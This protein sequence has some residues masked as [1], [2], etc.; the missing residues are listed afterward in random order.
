MALTGCGGGSD[1]PAAAPPAPAPAPPSPPASTAGIELLAGGLGG[2]GFVESRGTLARL[3]NP[4]SLA[5][6]KDGVVYFSTLMRVGKISAS[7]DVTFLAATFPDITMPGMACDSQGVLHICAIGIGAIYRL[8]EDGNP[9]FEL[10]AGKAQMFPNG[11]FADGT[12]QAA[13]M[14]LPKAPVFDAS[15][16]LYF[17][18]AGNRAIRKMTPAGTVSTVAG[19]PANT[20]MVDGLGSAAGFEDPAGMVL[21]PDG[22]FLILD[23][24][25]FRRMTPAGQVTTLAATVPAVVA[26]SLVANDGTSLHALLGNSVVRLGLDGTT[27]LVAGSQDT[28]GYAEGAGSQALFN[29]PADLIASA[30]VLLVAERLN[31]VIRRVVPAT[32]QTSAWVGAAAQP[33]RVDGAGANA[34]F[35]AIGAVALDGAG[36]AYVTDTEQMLLRK[37]TPAGVV[38]TLFQDFPSRG[39]L[40]VDAAGNFYGVRG[41][42]IVK[43]TP[44]GVQSVFAGQ[45]EGAPGFADGAGVNARFASPAALAMDRQGNLLVGDTPGLSYGA[46][47]THYVTYT[48]GNTIRKISP[49]GEVSTFA[50]TPGRVIESEWTGTRGLD[51]VSDFPGTASLAFDGQNNVV[52]LDTKFGSVRRIAAAGGTPFV[53]ALIQSEQ[54]GG[55]T[56]YAIPGGLAVTAAGQVFYSVERR[57]SAGGGSTSMIRRVVGDGS[58]VVVAGHEQLD[59]F[60]VGIGPLPGSMARVAAMAAVANDTLLVASENSL[61][62]IQLA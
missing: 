48:Y 24:N 22:S 11:G 4:E 2:A 46:P 23:K 18:D 50:G 38:S 51:P 62:R 33:G 40:A 31:P 35:A 57:S 14:K 17:I 60:G 54:I 25:R 12:G 26:N 55:A 27:T 53:M 47:F 3:S 36:N 45:V 34:R 1:D 15:D 32:G 7:G 8:I 42:A 5:A 29:A 41:R 58:S 49:A 39:G 20:T 44:A 43:V 56:L 59:H 30:G 21:M 13:L 52:V 10:M 19:Q 37:V 61:L 9:R 6:G 16:N 28:A